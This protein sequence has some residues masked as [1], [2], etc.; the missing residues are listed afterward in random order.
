M[1]PGSPKRIS[2]F[3]GRSNLVV[4]KF[5]NRPIF[6][7]IRLWHRHNQ[8]PVG[9]DVQKSL[10]RSRASV[11]RYTNTD[12]RNL[13]PPFNPRD[14]ILIIGVTKRMLFCFIPTKLPLSWIF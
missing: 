10:N 12:P 13:N 5:T 6:L 4:V 14:S 11:Y 8:T 2:C 1:S 7:L 3:L 9:V